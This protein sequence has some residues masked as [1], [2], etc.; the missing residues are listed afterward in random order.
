MMLETEPI[1]AKAMTILIEIF[2]RASI[3]LSIRMRIGTKVK[4]Q[5]ATTLMTP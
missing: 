3:S 1:A 4:V 5:S 2:D